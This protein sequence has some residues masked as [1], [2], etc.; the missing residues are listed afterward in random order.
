LVFSLQLNVLKNIHLTPCSKNTSHKLLIVL[1]W[2][3]ECIP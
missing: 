1:S 3:S 2:S